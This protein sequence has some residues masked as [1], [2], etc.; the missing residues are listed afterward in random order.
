MTGT[1]QGRH[2][3]IDEL[4]EIEGNQQVRIELCTKKL[5]FAVVT[6]VTLQHKNNSYKTI[7]NVII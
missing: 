3:E 5:R 2:K 4:K 7:L 6:K 1:R